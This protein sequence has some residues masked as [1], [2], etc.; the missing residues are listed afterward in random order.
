MIHDL[1]PAVYFNGAV[2]SHSVC[3]EIKKEIDWTQVPPSLGITI[4]LCAGI[5]DNANLSPKEIAKQEVLE[6]CGYDVPLENFE[7]IIS[8]RYFQLK[9]IALI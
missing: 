8:Y 9:I 7:Y 1:F 3:N 4:E 2:T 5:L 6:E